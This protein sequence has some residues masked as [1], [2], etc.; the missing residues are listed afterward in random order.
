M[1]NTFYL[2]F[3]V[4]L[5][6]AGC[7]KESAIVVPP[8][9]AKLPYENDAI[10][11]ELAATSL[12]V[13]IQAVCF[14]NAA[15]G[16]A[17]TY[18]GKIYQTSDG[19]K[20]WALRYTATSTANLPLV[21]ILFTGANVGYVVG[22]SVSCNGAGCHPPGGLIL[23]TIDGGTTWAVVYQASNVR[24]ASLAVNSLGELLAIS[25]D[26]NA[27]ILKSADAGATWVAVATFPYQL[28]KI[29]FDRN[30][31][32][33]AGATGKILK[34]KDNG[35]TWAEVAVNF[36][37]PYLNELAFSTGIGFC[38]TGYS[39]VYK[40]ADDGVNWL[41]TSR[42]HFST[43]VINPLTPSSCLIFG[44]GRYSGGDF[45]TFDGSCRQSVDGGNSWSEIEL[46]DV[47]TVHY[48]SF[49][50][51]RNGYAVAGSSLL[52]VTVK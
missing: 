22:G 27:R 52:K 16:L 10:K 19:G 41:P 23:K 6:L 17:S 28:D 37:Y 25:D 7:K 5:S 43:Q 12:P 11:I 51:P 29:A 4:L 32:F 44:G 21:Q 8:I 14:T 24:I 45:G 48:A 31:G 50:T 42:S 1:K 47:S 15:I 46:S 49:Y 33:C 30:Q 38:A 35:T 26:A 3:L 2:L 36:T 20:T 9:V 34:S 40:T 13:W 18:D 39:Q